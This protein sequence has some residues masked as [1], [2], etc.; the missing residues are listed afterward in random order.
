MIHK[1][2]D[3]NTLLMPKNELMFSICIPTYNGASWIKETLQSILCQSYENYEIVISDDKS[4]DN[5]IEEINNIGDPRIT[6]FENESNVGYAKN[7][8]KLTKLSKGQ[9][10]FLMGQDDI[11]AKD[12][13]INTLNA[14]EIS[15]DV[16]AVTR[17]YYW[18]DKDIRKAVRAKQQYDEKKDSVISIKDGKDAVLSVFKTLDQLSGLAYRRN[19]IDT[20]F[21][22]DIFPCHVYPFASIFKKHKVVYLRD[23]TIAVRISSSQTRGV[24]WI[25]E[26][27]PVQSW[28]DMFNTIFREKEFDDI[29]KECVKNFVAKNY[30]GL[31]QIRNYAKYRFLLREILLLVKYR[32]TNL[33]NG[34]F[35]LFS[36]GA[37]IAPRS[38]LIKF[39]DLYKNKINSR[40]LSIE[41]DY[42]LGVTDEPVDSKITAE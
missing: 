7:L 11:L 9:I 28:V 30:I 14:F 10:I 13:L 40:F 24:Q 33:L 32:W 34:Q 27:S 42:D 16:G 37:M 29:R 22:E 15:D 23:H 19:L 31:A 2:I 12:A 5:T 18:F 17:P 6:I 39:V 36:L 8:G 35:W 1:R 41:F 38:L 26:K 3:Q 25:Y 4:T 20:P 21:H